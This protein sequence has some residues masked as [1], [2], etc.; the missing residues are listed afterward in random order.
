MNDY[1][2]LNEYIKGNS[3][4]AFKQLTER[5]TDLVYSIALQQTADPHLAEDITQ[6]VFIILAKKAHKLKKTT[7]LSGWLYRTVRFAA[8]NALRVEKRRKAHEQEASKLTEQYEYKPDNP[9]WSAASS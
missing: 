3:D 1:T 8:A 2:L 4:T 5:Y 7:V 6:T 9:K